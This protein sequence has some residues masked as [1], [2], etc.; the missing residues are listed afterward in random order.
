MATRLEMEKQLI[1]QKEGLDKFFGK[2]KEFKEERDGNRALYHFE[3]VLEWAK[4]AKIS[5]R[6]MMSL[7]EKLEIISEQ[8]IERKKEFEKQ[9]P[10]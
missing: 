9:K 5:C 6:E 8:D 3:G 10:E 7:L 4:C 2:W 1:I